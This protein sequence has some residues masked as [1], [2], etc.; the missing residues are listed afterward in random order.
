MRAVSIV[1]AVQERT[2]TPK[3]I[4]RGL[5]VT[6]K[7]QLK[8]RK[9]FEIPRVFFMKQATKKSENISNGKF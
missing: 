2:N 9:E 6:Q 5:S 3:L 1:L 7:E 4:Y 8:L